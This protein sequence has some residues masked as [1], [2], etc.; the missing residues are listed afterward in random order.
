MCGMVIFSL[1]FPSLFD[2]DKKRNDE[3]VAHNL[4][5]MYGISSNILS[6][7]QLREVLDGVN[8]QALRP[9]FNAVLAIAQRDN[10]LEQFYYLDGSL[11]VSVDGTEYF[12]SKKIHCD[13]CCVRKKRNG[14]LEYYHQALGA[15]IVHPDKKTVIPLA[16][17]PIAKQDGDNKNDCEQNASKR[18]LNRIR[19]EHPRLKMIIVEDALASNGPHIKE[20]RSLDMRFILGVKPGSN[21]E[22]FNIVER[23]MPY[24]RVQT[25]EIMDNKGTTHKFKFVNN[26]ALNKEHSDILVNFLEYWEIRGDKIL[27]FSWVTDITLSFD[28]VFKLIRAGRA[29]WKV[30]NETFNTLKNQ[31]YNFEHNFGHGNKNLSTVFMFLMMLSFLV[32]QLQEA[33]CALFQAARKKRGARRSLWEAMRTM[34]SMFHFSNWL[35]FWSIIIYAS[36]QK[37]VLPTAQAP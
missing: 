17:E 31:N 25:H 19:K 5:T 22:I 37:I 18:L 30:E 33:F 16:P 7:T 11:L 20:L 36:N 8:P 26:V 4:R 3:A 32:D 35:D 29:R 34:F 24:D 10:V 23:L 9:A 28:N 21:A 2:Y 14:T 15:V 12:S 1:K 6:D 13:Q 27:H